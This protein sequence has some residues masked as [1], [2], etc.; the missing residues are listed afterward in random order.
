MNTIQVYKALK[1]M[2][3]ET[4]MRRLEK[5]SEAERIQT[6]VAIERVLNFLELAKK[7]KAKTLEE[8]V[9]VAVLSDVSEL[10]LAICHDRPNNMTLH[11]HI[12]PSCEIVFEHDPHKIVNHVKAHTCPQGCDELISPIF[13]GRKKPKVK[14]WIGL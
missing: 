13:R 10:C 5:M 12:C 9:D 7:R 6:E 2:S 14:G 1:K 3:L 4:F 11:S 8:L